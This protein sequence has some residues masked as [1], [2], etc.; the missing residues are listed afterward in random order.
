MPTLKTRMIFISHAWKY[1]EHYWKPVGWFNEKPNFS[2]KTAAFLGM[3][4]AKRPPKRIE[5][6]SCETDT[7]I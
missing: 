3:M 4:H 6:V 1:D 2:W 5:G 7:C